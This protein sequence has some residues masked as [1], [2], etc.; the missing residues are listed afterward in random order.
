M[1]TRRWSLPVNAADGG[2]SW[3]PSDLTGDGGRPASPAWLRA[4]AIGAV[5]VLAGL[6]AFVPGF[7]A[8]PM[9]GY[10]VWIAAIAL[11]ERIIP[12]VGR[13]S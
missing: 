5:L 12:F 8:V 1:L 4:L 9:W 10:P 13:G 7:D 3:K 6:D 2:G 11:G